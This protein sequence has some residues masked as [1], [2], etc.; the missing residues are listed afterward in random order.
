MI[1][2]IG[3]KKISS[4]SMRAWL[5]LKAAGAV[6]EEREHVFLDDWD[7]QRRQWGKFSPTAQVPVLI[8]GETC[9]WDSL[10]ICLYIGGRFPEVWA[11]DAAARAWSYSA[12]AEMHAGFT[13]LRSRC[14]RPNF[15]GSIH[16]GR[17]VCTVSAVD[18]WQA[19]VLPPS[20]RFTPLWCCGCIVTV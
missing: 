20:M 5:A 8:D 7:E 6:F 14:Y 12:A 3:D 10:A 4:W 17:K 16:C 1:L 18:F 11:D 9:I 2:H 15:H 13:V 19:A